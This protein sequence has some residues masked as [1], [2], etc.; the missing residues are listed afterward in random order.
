MLNDYAIPLPELSAKLNAQFGRAGPGYRKLA[1]MAADG[2][3]PVER[4]RG[5]WFVRNDR[6]GE[7]AEMLGLA[8]RSAT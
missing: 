2:K 5:R 1:E 8:P 6:V 4:H 7:I 3:L